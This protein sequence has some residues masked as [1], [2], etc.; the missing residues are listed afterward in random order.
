MCPSGE[1]T[2]FLTMNGIP[3]DNYG[4][5]TQELK[6]AIIY[7]KEERLK[8]FEDDEDN[9]ENSEENK[10]LKKFIITK[11]TQNKAEINPDVISIDNGYTKN[12]K[13]CVPR[14]EKDML[15]KDQEHHGFI[16]LLYGLIMD[17]IMK[18]NLIVFI[19]TLLNLIMP[20]AISEK[21][22]NFFSNN[23]IQLKNILISK[24][25]KMIE[26]YK[27]LSAYL[28]WKIWQIGQNQITEFVSNCPDLLDK[29]YLIND[30]LV[31]VTEVKSNAIDK[32]DKKRTN[33]I[34]DNI[35]RHQFMSLL[36]KITKYFR[37]KQ[38]PSIVDAVEYSFQHHYD[39]YLNQFDNHKWRKERYYNEPVDN[40]LKAFIPILAPYFIHMLPNK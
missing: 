22:K 32:Q 17:I 27:N 25:K 1:L 18:A 6:D 7:T 28:G 31:K 12:I 23:K 16:L 30:V 4:P 2:F 11:V 21:I 33:N 35:I 36:V 3:V 38:M 26:T 5:I 8:E 24:Y 37:T 10:K 29:N 19:M 20:G 15:K 40:I 14:P 9:N 34:P 13:Y 39:Y